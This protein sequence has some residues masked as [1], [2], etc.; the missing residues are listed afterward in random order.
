MRRPLYVAAGGGGDALAAALLHHAYGRGGSPV[1]ATLSWDRLIVDPLPGPRSIGDFTGLA[2]IDGLFN[3]VTPRTR[4][5]PPAGSTLP[6][7]ARSLTG[8]LNATLVLLDATGGVIDLHRQLVAHIAATSADGVVLVDVGGDVL[9]LGQEPGLRSPLGDALL[10]AA[11]AGLDVPSAVWIAGP[12]VD[13]ELPSRY[14]LA[15]LESV[16]ATVRDALPGET[17]EL[18]LPILRWHPSEATALFVAAAHGVRG[19]VDIRSGGM[20]VRL[21]VDSSLVLEAGRDQ[22]IEASPLAQLIR[23]TESLTEADSI[24]SDACGRSEISFE[25]AKAASQSLRQ[26]VLNLDLSLLTSYVRQAEIAGVTHATYRRI[27][28]LT[29]VDDT[30]VVRDLLLARWP[31]SEDCCIW[32]VPTKPSMP[33]MLG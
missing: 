10:L 27:A 20:P 28:E 33:S 2:T 11:V 15:R 18:A 6:A 29:G 8:P 5:I 3:V 9:A 12:G 19:V 31:G 13:G 32:K 24:V 4:P 23:T 22:V 7:L 1:I 25:T 30:R 16:G 21:D 17:T 26:K 14:V